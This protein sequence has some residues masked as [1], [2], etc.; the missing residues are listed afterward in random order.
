M[1]LIIKIGLF[2]LVLV[3]VLAGFGYIMINRWVA[4]RID[5]RLE[6]KDR[7]MPDIVIDTDPGMTD[8]SSWDEEEFGGKS[9]HPLVARYDAEKRAKF[10]E[11]IDENT[12]ELG[13]LSD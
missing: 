2:L 4:G 10:N 5:E 9:I 12:M 8:T 3:V 7:A 1:W 6:G 11:D 13:Y